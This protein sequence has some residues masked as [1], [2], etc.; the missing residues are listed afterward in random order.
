MDEKEPGLRVGL[1]SPTAKVGGA[2]NYLRNIPSVW[3]SNWPDDELTVLDRRNSSGSSIKRL[4]VKPKVSDLD[5]IIYAGNFVPLLERSP[6]VLLVRNPIYFSNHHMQRVLR[7]RRVKTA[8]TIRAQ[9][10]LCLSSIRRATISCTPSLSMKGQVA[11]FDQDLG[12]RMV[13]L[14]HLAPSLP[15]LSESGAKHDIAYVTLPALHKNYRVLL[16]AGFV[17]QL[18]GWQG[19][20]HLIGTQG[21]PDVEVARRLVSHLGLDERIQWHEPDDTGNRF[22]DMAD[23]LANPALEESFGFG[24]SEGAAFGKQTVAADTPIARERLPDTS[25]VRFAGAE[26]W[27]DWADRLTE[28]L[29]NDNRAESEIGLGSWDNTV[30]RLRQIVRV[31]QAIGPTKKI[32]RC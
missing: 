20:L 8:L 11:R 16:L 26:D 6:T 5:T 22:Y 12:S 15:I 31:A 13:V 10:S 21:H 23:V 7:S 17:L 14:P 18:R 4:I 30:E 2:A 28:A 1:F 9:R 29:N 25:S 24:Y 19:H 27:L 32:W 3:R